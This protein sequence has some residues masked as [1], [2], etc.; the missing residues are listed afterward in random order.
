MRRDE[1][2]SGG[3]PSVEGGQ[4]RKADDKGCE[5][6]PFVHILL[7]VDTIVVSLTL[8]SSSA[9]DRIPYSTLSRLSSS[10]ARDRL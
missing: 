3:C 10:P 8:A 7:F 9:S 4:G 1:W 6:S 5:Y 2:V